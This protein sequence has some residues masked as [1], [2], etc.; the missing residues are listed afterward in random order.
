MLAYASLWPDEQLFVFGVIPTTV[1]WL[2]VFVGVLNI[3]GG[4]TTAGAV[5]AESHTSR[6]SADSRRAG[7]TCA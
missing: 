5:R 7:S 1:R 4:I 6:T 3:V 2:V